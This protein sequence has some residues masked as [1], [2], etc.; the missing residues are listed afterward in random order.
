MGRKAWGDAP[1]NLEVD[2]HLQGARFTKG[3]P[4]ANFDHGWFVGQGFFWRTGNYDEICVF[5]KIGTV[6]QNG[7][8]IMENPL[9][10]H[11]L[12]GKPTIFGNTHMKIF[13]KLLI[14]AF[15]ECCN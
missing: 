12:G 1:V 10:M 3:G 15:G 14:L 11:D 5:P 2:Q 9:K 6:P 8:F 4:E 7:W 13:P